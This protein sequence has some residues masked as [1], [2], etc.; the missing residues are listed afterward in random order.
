MDGWKGINAVHVG[1]KPRPF[2]TRHEEHAAGWESPVGRY[3][4]VSGLV[5]LSGEYYAGSL[6]GDSG[7]YRDSQR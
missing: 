5:C 1:E 6:S 7:R 3:A 2:A 4:A